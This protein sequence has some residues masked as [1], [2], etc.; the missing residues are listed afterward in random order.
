MRINR[1][2]NLR[3]SENMRNWSRRTSGK[4][5]LTSIKNSRCRCVAIQYNTRTLKINAF[6]R[7]KIMISV[8]HK[9]KSSAFANE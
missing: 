1:G 8:Q 2:D 5:E 3:K 9:Y 4:I 6:I 7:I